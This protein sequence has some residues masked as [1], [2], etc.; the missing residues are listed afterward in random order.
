[1]LRTTGV[2]QF[3][4]PRLF[5]DDRFFTLD[6]RISPEGQTQRNF[7]VTDLRE[8]PGSPVP[9]LQGFG[10]AGLR[11]D[12]L[13]DGSSRAT[14]VPLGMPD[15][16]YDV[17]SRSVL[18]GPDNFGITGSGR[19][20]II[21]RPD[22]DTLVGLY[23]QS[24]V[25]GD[26]GFLKDNPETPTS[27]PFRAGGS[28]YGWAPV[29]NEY[30][31]SFDASLFDTLAARPGVQ[32][33]AGV[34]VNQ[35]ALEAAIGYM[36]QGVSGDR[37]PKSMRQLQ[38]QRLARAPQSV[39]DTSFPLADEFISEAQMFREIDEDI[40]AGSWMEDLLGGEAPGQMTREM[41]LPR[42]GQGQQLRAGDE[43]PG[44]VNP[45]P[46][47]VPTQGGDDMARKADIRMSDL[48]NMGLLERVGRAESAAQNQKQLASAAIAA[49]RQLADA[50]TQ[51]GDV[52][53]QAYSAA[54]SVPYMRAQQARIQE[55][56]ARQSAM[57]SVTPAAPTPAPLEAAPMRGGE[58][59]E[60]YGPSIPSQGQ[61]MERLAVES[62][63]ANSRQQQIQALSGSTYIPGMS[64]IQSM[65][66]ELGR[67]NQ[68]LGAQQTELDALRLQDQTKQEEIGRLVQLQ[69]GPYQDLMTYGGAG[70]GAAG[71]IYGLSQPGSPEPSMPAT[72]AYT[73]DPFI[74]RPSYPVYAY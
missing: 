47:F 20:A 53:G 56:E 46:E 66:V 32:R 15:A 11:Y 60:V 2:G 68:L 16:V 40:A 27:N 23:Q 58:A 36:T 55:L 19:Q 24:K 70:L 64:R 12:R 30:G 39:L 45:R 21:S 69:K 9:D 67:K 73:Q 29:T 42:K 72:A 57:E 65:E 41:M 18:V 5:R 17:A 44:S 48:R 33:E 26:F 31:T 63:L 1:M 10:R 8:V 14:V 3:L 49:N 37:A 54:Y 38:D 61:L 35:P 50:A 34:T 51:Y 52:I 6:R 13:P 22:M 59:V 7:Q 74:G 28:L 4:N 43:L 62:Q 71:V 25:P